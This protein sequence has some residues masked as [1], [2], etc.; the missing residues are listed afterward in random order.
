[1]MTTLNDAT[2]RKPVEERP[3]LDDFVGVTQQYGGVERAECA[4]GSC[5]S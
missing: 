1:M 2:K 4:Q 5:N 3:N